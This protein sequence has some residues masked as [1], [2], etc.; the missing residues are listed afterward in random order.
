MR[1]S[2][3]GYLR[4]HAYVPLPVAFRSLSRPSSAPDAK[5]FP[6]RS[7]QLDLDCITVFSQLFLE[8]C[9]HFFKSSLFEIVV[10]P[11]SGS[12]FPQL[13]SKFV[14]LTLLLSV[15]L[16]FFR[17]LS[18]LFSFQGAKFRSLLKPDII[19]WPSRHKIIS[20]LKSAFLVGLRGLEP[21]TL[22]LSVVRSSQLS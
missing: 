11:F 18:V 10:L 15:A 5:A 17:I 14:G 22:R 12:N 7:F 6:L 19:S 16:L 2:P 13:L 4:I 3:F 20:V 9:R 21:P 8:L 1:V